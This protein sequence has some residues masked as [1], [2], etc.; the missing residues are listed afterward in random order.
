MVS[1]FQ[2]QSLPKALLPESRK[3][4]PAS[5]LRLD[6]EE[7]VFALAVGEESQ[8]WPLKSF[9]ERPDVRNATIGGKK[10]LILWDGRTRTA[11]AFSPETEGDGAESVTLAVDASDLESPY[12]DKET[13]SRWSVA[14]RAVSGPRKGQALRWLPGVMVKWYAWAASY[15]KTYLEGKD[16]PKR[17]TR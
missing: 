13:G 1:K 16:G 14:G 9:G 10:A 17:A 2:P 5:D 8:A 6:A 12:V 4:R 11:A 3:T 7:R 15:P